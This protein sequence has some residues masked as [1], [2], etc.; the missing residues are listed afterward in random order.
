MEEF[1]ARFGQ[2]IIESFA[3]IIDDTVF[4]C[5][6][7]FIINI[8][9]QNGQPEEIGG[10]HFFIGPGGVARGFSENTGMKDAFAPNLPFF[11]YAY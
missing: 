3:H 9:G 5:F 1:Y 11:D 2:F 7:F 10:L 4:E 8:F 6:N